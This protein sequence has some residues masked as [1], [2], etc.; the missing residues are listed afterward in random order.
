MAYFEIV[1]CPWF[2]LERTIK[3]KSEKMLSTPKEPF[4]LSGEVRPT[5]ESI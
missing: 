2:Y 5:G 3:E 1:E 4:P